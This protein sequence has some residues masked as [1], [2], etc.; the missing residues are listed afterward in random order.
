MG[1]NYNRRR[2]YTKS[3]ETIRKERYEAERRQRL[4]LDT[5]RRIAIAQA[6]G[7]AL[8]P[9]DQAALDIAIENWAR[10]ASRPSQRPFAEE[11]AEIR[12]RARQ[13]G[14]PDVP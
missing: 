6:F 13:Q 10:E 4:L 7:V 12:E 5:F 3:N 2:Y 11:L 1:T 9:E 14:L 8:T